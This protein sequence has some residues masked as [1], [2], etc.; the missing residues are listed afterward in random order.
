MNTKELDQ[1]HTN[2]IDLS[3]QLQTTLGMMENLIN[4]L[5]TPFQEEYTPEDESIN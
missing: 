4:S 3:S 1:L 5:E 2:L